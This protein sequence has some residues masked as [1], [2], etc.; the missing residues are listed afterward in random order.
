MNKPD[1]PLFN[2]PGA[3]RRLH[4]RRPLRVQAT[5]LVAQQTVTVRTLDVSESGLGFMTEINPP[6]GMRFRIAFAC[7]KRPQGFVE[8]ACDA[9]VM[10]SV[11]S[12]ADGGYRVGCRFQGLSPTMVN[13]LADF[14]RS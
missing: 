1:S 10:G 11:F 6:P 3:N 8:I 12:I 2:L 4:D 14:V 9:Q 5:L 7:P 13:A